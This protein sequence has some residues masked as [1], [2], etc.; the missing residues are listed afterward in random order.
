[1]PTIGNLILRSYTLRI[2]YEQHV[3]TFWP[4]GRPIPTGHRGF[5]LGWDYDDRGRARVVF[6][7]ERSAAFAAG[8]REGYAIERIGGSTI[9]ELDRDALCHLRRDWAMNTDMI[10]LVVAGKTHC[11]RRQSLFDEAESTEC[12]D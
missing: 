12:V 6:V 3:A 9:A 10:E 11:L 2:D 4:N 5:G 1:V 7:R 8:I